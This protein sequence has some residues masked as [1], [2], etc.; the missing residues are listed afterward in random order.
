MPEKPF[1]NA[2]PGALYRGEERLRP[3]WSSFYPYWEYQGKI[4]RGA[5][6]ANPDF[7]RYIDRSIERARQV[8]LNG[9]RATDYLEGSN[10]WKDK[11]VWQNVDYFLKATHAAGMDVIVN[12][13]PFRKWLIRNNQNPYNPDL[14]TEYLPFIGEKLAPWRNILYVP[15]AGE[16]PPP[17][18]NNS[19]KATARGYVAFYRVVLDRLRRVEPNHLHVVGGLSFLNRPQYGI[20]WEELFSLPGNDL[21]AL[22]VYSEGDLMVSL[23]MLA[24]WARKNSKP[25]IL[26]EFGAKQSE[27]DDKRA[28]YF[29]RVFRAAQDANVAGLGFWNLGS[30]SAPASYQVGEQT[31]QTW[32][33]VRRNARMFQSVR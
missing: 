10:D 8:G 14:W 31:P 7:G 2:R 13:D 21:V 27:G 26:E 16:V 6:W 25:L 18:S 4:L 22:H 11:T 12:I 3:V 29:D 15:V 1:I 9:L 23:P 5:G 20:P 28:G 19:W 32:A 17:E 30:E 33:A 24:D